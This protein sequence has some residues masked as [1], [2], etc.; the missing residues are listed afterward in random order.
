VTKQQQAEIISIIGQAADLGFGLYFQGDGRTPCCPVGYLLAAKGRILG[1]G[2]DSSLEELYGLSGRMHSQIVVTN[3][4]QQYRHSIEAR[5]EAVLN[6]IK[7]FPT[8]D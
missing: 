4:S 7:S 8:E 6:L 5:K 1:D 2:I 3:D